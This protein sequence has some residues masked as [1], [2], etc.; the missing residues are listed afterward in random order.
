[1]LNQGGNAYFKAN[2]DVAA[3]FAKDAYGM[4]AD[5][6]ASTHFNK[7]GAT[8]GRVAPA[9]AAMPNATLSAG[10][11][12]AAKPGGI[13]AAKF[14]QN[15]RDYLAVN[16][17]ATAA[18]KRT[19]MDLYGISDQDVSRATM[20]VAPVVA[21]VVAR[22]SPSIAAPAPS[23]TGLLT[24]G[25]R[26]YF[27]ANPDVAEAFS[28]DSFG[29]TESQFADTH[30]TKFGAAE[31]RASPASAAVPK[32]TLSA[33]MTYA[34]RQGGIGADAYYSNIRNWANST[35]GATESDR[36]REMQAYGVSEE[37]WSRSGAVLR[38]APVAAPVV[39]PVVAELNRG[40]N[41]RNETIEGRIQGL[42]GTD[43]QG[44]Y[45]NPVVRQAS[46]RAMQTFA[47]RGLLNSS[48][49]QQAAIEAAVGKAIEIA[50]PDAQTY[51]SQGRA[52]QDAGNVFA[53]DELS[54]A[55][56]MQKQAAQFAQQDKELAQRGGQFDREFGLKGQ[57]LA[58]RGG[59]FD[60]ELASKF[61]LAK[62]DITSRT[63]AT[64]LAQKNALEINNIAAVNSQFDLYLR[65]ISEI[66]SNKDFDDVVK[67]KLKNEAGADFDTFARAANIVRETMGG[68]Y[69]VAAPAANTTAPTGATG[70]M[71]SQGDNFA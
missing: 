36:Q 49:A 41:A 62:L 50:G 3:A 14:D 55:R 59:Q 30:F 1:M 71:L 64:E 47:G 69:T 53:R 24:Q 35:P 54:F 20:P 61:D 44:N 2:P 8:E 43:A 18:Q 17:T 45:T 27:Q 58:Q 60:R 56:D 46:D 67:V 21:P 37:D 32:T 11:A 34:S 63:Q 33:G 19:E 29:M 9:P 13:G 52:N 5:A 70:G 48:M 28:K 38:P 25:S 31:G 40:V 12:Y 10:A 22:N 65:R 51:F 39:A 4:S 6:F 66:D 7:F 42:L 15:I 26:S 23:P 68:R 16:P 57:E